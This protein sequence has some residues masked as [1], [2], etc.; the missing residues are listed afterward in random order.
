MNAMLDCFFKC[1]LSSYATLGS[2][3]YTIFSVFLAAAILLLLRRW[4]RNDVREYSIGIF[5]KEAHLRLISSP[6]TNRDIDEKCI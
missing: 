6:L 3:A 2:S 1:F 4:S 5:K